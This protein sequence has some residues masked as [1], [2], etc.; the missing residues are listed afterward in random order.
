MQ[1]MWDR[2]RENWE[3]E[4]KSIGLTLINGQLSVISNH[5]MEYDYEF[6]WDGVEILDHGRSYTKR[7][8]IISEMI[9]IA[10]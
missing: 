5:R 3:P 7:D 4:L 9:R 1:H 2:L 8:Y 10:I 6:D